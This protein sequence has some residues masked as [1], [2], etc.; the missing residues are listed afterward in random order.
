MRN[1]KGGYA[2]NQWERIYAA[3]LLVS[4]GEIDYASPKACEI[5][6]KTSEE[7]SAGYLYQIP[8]E[9]LAGQ[10][11]LPDGKLVLILES[12]GS[13][14]N[15]EEIRLQNA[16]LQNALHIAEAASEAKTSFLSNMSH[17]IRTPMNAI[18]GMTT[19]ALKHIDEKAR[20]KD[21]LYKIQTA[22]NHLMSLINNVLDIS[23]IDSGKTVI[24]EEQF[25]LPDLVH[26]L[27]VL[28]RPLAV[29]KEHQ[30]SFDVE[31]I[32]H[33]TLMG[34][35]LYLRQI[36]V[37]IINNAIKYTNKGGI[38]HVCFSEVELPDSSQVNLC[39]TCKDNGMGMSKE[40][41]QKIFQP[42]TRA[43]GTA[44]AQ[45]EGTG[46]GMAITHSLVG[47]MNG[48]IQ[49]ESEPGKGSL[50]SISVPLHI[51]DVKE[52]EKTLTGQTILVV[53]SDT[54]QTDVLSRYI[55]EAGGEVI[56]QPTGVDA[57]TWITQA[58]VEGK[59]L[60]AVLLAGHTPE[61][62]VLNLATYLRGQMKRK[63]PILL[64]SEEDWGRI[65][66]G[67]RRAGITDFVPCPLFR[68]RLL[69]ALTANSLSK[70]KAG[71]EHHFNGMKILLAEDNEI[72]R[73]I[74]REIIRSTGAYVDEATN[75]QE[76]VNIFTASSEGY[77]D[78]I[79]M[80]IQ[81]PVMDGYDA[82]KNIRAL[83]RSDA[84]TV[85]IAAM[86]ANA[87]VE[88]IKRTKAAG[89]NEHLSKPINI[90]NFME[91]LHRCYKE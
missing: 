31:G 18:L 70:E 69:N 21:C 9:R 81:M 49:I 16:S 42:F 39:F 78:L 64:V 66:Y 33:E 41:I 88:D 40:F 26:D 45:T 85:C 11:P 53:S 63:V 54:A 7:L 89:M 3:Y 46:L 2:V 90:E 62:V 79:L 56:L 43:D 77:Y 8:K 83:S 24:S 25:S 72:N 10:I 50:F 13:E 73:E 47:K 44:V 74:E 12:E 48:S 86:T 75:G 84:K 32:E 58:Q 52:H 80:D 82:V 61:G 1:Q 91:L 4:K 15:I 17:D 20:V 5:L 59:K 65:E 55:K 36:F 23:R 71:M 6:G 34:D 19:I 30:L 51:S 60:G 35:V 28:L 57:V 29:A 22:S 87:F 67:A 76:A 14:N 38:I 27:T 37:N 68:G